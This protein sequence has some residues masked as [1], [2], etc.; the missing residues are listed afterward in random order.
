M[1]LFEPIY[2]KILVWAKHRHA[3]RY[4]AGISFAESSFFPIPVDVMLA[5]MVLANHQKAWRLATI[6]TITSVAG[7]CFGFLIGAFFFDAYGTQLIEYF[8]AQDTFEGVKASYIEHGM[9]IV[10]LAGFTPVPYKIFTIASGVIGIAFL[11]FVL[12]SLVSRGARFF[13]V[14]GLIKLG[15]DK[16]EANIHRTVE[17]LG[18]GTLI[19]A[20]LAF[21][22]YRYWW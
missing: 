8:N 5:P 22:V 20:G 12:M 15:G 1:R 9:L 6:T 11:P 2:S 19:L 21:V 4:L 18:W 16:L 17:W 7:G 14:A 13:L 3:E 10:L